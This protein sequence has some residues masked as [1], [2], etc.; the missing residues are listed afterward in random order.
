MSRRNLPAV[1]RWEWG[2]AGSFLRFRSP[3][4]DV[5]RGAL[6]PRPVVDALAAWVAPSVPKEVEGREEPPAVT[7]PV[8][9]RALAQLTVGLTEPQRRWGGVLTYGD[10]LDMAEQYRHA[11]RDRALGIVDGGWHVYQLLAALSEEQWKRLDG[12]GLRW[13]EDVTVK[14]GPGD[15]YWSSFRKG[16]GIAFATSD[17]KGSFGAT[18]P[19]GTSTSWRWLSLSMLGSP[20]YQQLPLDL[21]LRPEVWKHLVGATK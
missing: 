17:P 2:D 19:S 15:W 14:A 16:D 6:L 13:G 3:E 4:R 5:W 7:V 18:L 10:P 11:M 9:P 21:V 1:A 8:D 20:E 12:D